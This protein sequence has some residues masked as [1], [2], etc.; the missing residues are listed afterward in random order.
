MAVLCQSLAHLHIWFHKQDCEDIEN[1]DL[2]KR[3]L[4]LFYLASFAGS[5]KSHLCCR[6]AEV[7]DGLR[8]NDANTVS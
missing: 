6:L 4:C 2:V 3:R 5:G 1:K 8:Q 7:L